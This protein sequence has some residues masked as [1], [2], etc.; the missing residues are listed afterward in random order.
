MDPRATGAQD[1][2]TRTALDTS[3]IVAAFMSWQ[4]RHE[5]SLAAIG[6]CHGPGHRLVLP[7]PALVQSFSVMTRLPPHRRLSTV[8]A[9][10]YL[11]GAFEE[12]T[13]LVDTPPGS[14][15]E[16]LGDAVAAGVVGGAIHDY[17]I[18]ECAVAAKADRLLTLDPDDFRRF[19]DRGVEFVA[20]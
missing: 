15:W 3:V 12:G 4:P 9:L 2:V 6:R 8:D 11:H 13:D 5:E 7:I 16:M 10:A 14:A 19:G 1:P 17:Q 20:P 18:L